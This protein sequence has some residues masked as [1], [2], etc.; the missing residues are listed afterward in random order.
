MLE[1]VIPLSEH[2][3]EQILKTLD[4]K[5]D[6]ILQSQN[7]LNVISST[8]ACAGAIYKKF[9]K[10]CPAMMKKFNKYLD[11]LTMMRDTTNPT[12]EFTKEKLGLLRR[13][14]FSVGVI[15]R[16]F[17]LD[18]IAVRHDVAD[19][20]TTTKG[21]M[22]AVVL[23]VLCHFCIDKNA[24]LKLMALKAFGQLTAQ[25]PEYLMNKEVQKIYS[26]ALKDK[27]SAVLMQALQNLELFL[28]SMEEKA[29]KSNELCK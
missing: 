25:C 12:V 2:P 7:N 17:D 21:G 5:L 23:D 1:K 16:Y 29:I 8:V 9:P 13:V 28:V 22:R 14:L 11:Y 3:G 19:L 6:D 4:G 10:Y 24:L 18:A 15:A 26:D 20:R 27:K